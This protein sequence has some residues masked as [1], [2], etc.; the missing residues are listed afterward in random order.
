MFVISISV[1]PGFD[2]RMEMYKCIY[3]EIID[4]IWTQYQQNRQRSG[5]VSR[6]EDLSLVRQ[7]Q[8]FATFAIVID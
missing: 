7:K 6:A 1:S 8:H 5:R 2:A 3:G 4:G